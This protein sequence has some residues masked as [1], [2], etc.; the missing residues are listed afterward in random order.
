ME[1]RAISQ[2]KASLGSA[3]RIRRWGLFVLL[4]RTQ[5]NKIAAS[6]VPRYFAW[7]CF[8]YFC[9]GPALHRGRDAMPGPGIML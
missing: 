8:R 1:Q 7:G 9:P 2:K 4:P 5:R 3:M 6:Q